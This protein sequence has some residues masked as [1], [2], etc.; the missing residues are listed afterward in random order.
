MKKHDSLTRHEAVTT[1]DDA[2][3]GYTLEE[4]RYRRAYVGAR[5]EMEKERL[6]YN[7]ASLR[8]NTVSS[9][10]GVIKRVGSAL[11]VVKYVVAAVGIGSKIVGMFRRRRK[12]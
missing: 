12:R 11:P 1:P 7:V 2:W 10:T 3:K 8:S 6:A 5:R 9:A 4:L